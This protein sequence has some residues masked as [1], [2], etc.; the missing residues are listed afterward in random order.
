MNVDLFEEVIEPVENEL[1]GHPIQDVKLGEATSEEGY[2]KSLL[3]SFGDLIEIVVRGEKKRVY[4]W[5]WEVWNSVWRIE[6]EGKVI[7]GSGKEREDLEKDLLV[8]QGKKLLGVT[9]TP[10]LLD[11][12][13]T[14][15]S[16]LT[17]KTFV[18]DEGEYQWRLHQPDGEV[19]IAS[20][21]DQST[22]KLR[23]K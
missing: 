9:I 3:L 19:F 21:Q 12:S 14:F 16:G 10:R 13:L 18:A 4:A 7:T 22:V 5:I 15:E 20:S 1:I 11:V 23:A 17:V 6:K 8:L 2:D